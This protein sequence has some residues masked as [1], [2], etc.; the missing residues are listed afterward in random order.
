MVEEYLNDK[1]NMELKLKDYDYYDNGDLGINAGKHY[2]F[3]FKQIID[4]RKCRK[5]KRIEYIKFSERKN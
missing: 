2:T 1:Y 5:C 3:N 4:R